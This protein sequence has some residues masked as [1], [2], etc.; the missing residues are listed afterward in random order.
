MAVRIGFG[1]AWS[2]KETKEAVGIDRTQNTRIPGLTNAV[3]A[4]RVVVLGRAL[5][6]I[7]EHE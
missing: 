7:L 2:A 1:D 5:I 3:R 4:S 6:A